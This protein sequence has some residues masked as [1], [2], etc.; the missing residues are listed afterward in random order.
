MPIYEFKCAS[1]G[2]QFEELILGHLDMSEICCPKCSK[3]EVQR[4]LSVFSGCGTSSG[5][6]S[7]ASCS[8]SSRFS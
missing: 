7:G 6:S 5:E 3:K 1:C 4:L 8:T 2:H